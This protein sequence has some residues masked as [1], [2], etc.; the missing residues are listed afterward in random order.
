MS[1]G[2]AWFVRPAAVFRTNS[3]PKARAVSWAYPVQPT[4]CSRAVYNAARTSASGRPSERASPHE[5]A[6]ERSASPA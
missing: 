3:S 1:I 5:S 2:S 4:W 6:H